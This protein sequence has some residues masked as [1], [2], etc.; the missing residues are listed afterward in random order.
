M[1]ALIG[2]IGALGMASSIAVNLILVHLLERAER[3]TMVVAGV[4]A[5]P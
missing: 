1:L 5:Q 3:D 4:R 2:V